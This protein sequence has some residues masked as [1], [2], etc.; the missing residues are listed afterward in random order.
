MVPTSTSID[1][2]EQFV[3]CYTVPDDDKIARRTRSRHPAWAT[4]TAARTERAGSRR[5]RPRKRGL[6]AEGRAIKAIG[7]PYEGWCLTFDTETT[8]D[9]AQALRFG[10]YE[11][12]GLDRD[13]RMRLCRHRRLTREALDTLQEAGIFY[14]PATLSAD[15]LAVIADYARERDL[16]CLT[17][18]QFVDRLYW[19]MLH[20]DALCIGHNLP[21]DL[22][23]LATAWTEAAGV[24]AAASPSSSVAVGTA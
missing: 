23:R 4:R 15:D 5:P 13:D 11:V 9:T 17:R 2:V 12:H 3:R 22:S 1:Y 10:C 21:F 14:D 8:T 6:S 7:A 16:A 18:D 19:W 20:R 24:T